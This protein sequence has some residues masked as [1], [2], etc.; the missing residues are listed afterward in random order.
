M[1]NVIAPPANTTNRTSGNQEDKNSYYYTNGQR[2]PLV[3][4]PSV[5]AVRYKVGRDSRDGSLSQEASRLL[6]EV[7]ENIGF[8]PYYAL[9]VYRADHSRLGASLPAY[10][11]GERTLT[12]AVRNLKSESPVEYAAI[13]FRRNK[14]V[15]V[16]NLDDLMFITREFAVQF[17]ENISRRE[18]DEL[19][20]RYRVEIVKELDYAPNGYVLRAPEAEGDNGPVVLANLYY[21]SGMAVFAHPN[22]VQRHHL[23]Q[24]ILEKE[25]SKVKKIVTPLAVRE[26]QPRTEF[27]SQQWHLQTAKVTDA[28]NI[29]K[30][31]NTIKVAILDDGVDTG[32]PEFD[33][34]VVV[35]F[36]FATGDSDGNPNLSSENHGTACAGVA[37]AKGVK[38]SGA[39]PDCS[40]IA[41]HTPDFLGTVEEAEMFQWVADQG[42]DVISCSWGPADGTGAVD[43]LPDNVRAAIHYCVTKG[44][45]GKG[46]PVF[47]AAGNGNESVS[48]DGYAANP[49]VFAVGA[50][51][52]NERRAWYSDFGPEVFI[53]APSSGDRS[54]RRIFTVDRRGN[55]GYNPDP[56]T[57][58]SHPA[59][60]ND[61]TDDFGGTSSAT[62]L[63]A[64]I[65]G[66]ILSVKPELTVQQ[67]RE[68]LRDTT[69]KIDQA[70]GNYDSNGHSNLY[71]YGR[72]NALKAVEK[73][74]GTS[75][76][77]GGGGQPTGQL[78]ITGPSSISRQD[79]APTFQIG[80]GG[81]A[82][83]AVEVATR[84]DLFDFDGHGSER[85][86]GNF[87]ASWQEAMLT[88][89]PFT[90][91]SAAWDQLKQ[92][93]QLFYRL[94]VA[95]DNNWSNHAA[96]VNDSDAS[97]AP[98]MQITGGGGGGGE[99]PNTG[100]LFI[101]GPSSISREDPAPTFQIGMGGRAM[102]A[103]EV[104]IRADLFD[105]DGHGSE[106]NDG[107][108]YA[109]WQDAM[110][111]QTPFTLPSAAWDQLKQANQLFYRLHVADDNN[112]SNHAA[113]VNDSDA[114]SAPS[115]QITDGTRLGRREM[116]TPAPRKEGS[117]TYFNIWSAKKEDEL[118]WR[119]QPLYQ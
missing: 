96:T 118:L 46:I 29:T 93:N 31:S 80:M 77:G 69:D 113:T 105:F 7:S 10:G 101:T 111:T 25:K 91:P 107:N 15:P 18:I 36:D 68:I 71:G 78:F 51:T 27:L 53:C 4:D 114:S 110:L 74:R 109:S 83:Y 94:H 42:A 85:N 119:G 57:G 90:L 26:V 37:V 14:D 32:H 112:W 2:I 12:A 65:T 63:V 1:K 20:S 24:G 66:L 11:N 89:T 40:L 56:D 30:G 61:Y 92:A 99:Q 72:V 73:A 48:N 52:N 98:S 45:G 62:P 22:F 16:R 3:K 70:N 64:G 21:E 106:R 59:G 58:V 84:S 117:L 13:A 81:R 38:A 17:K 108:F 50:S 104:A 41:I 19:N 44:R 9:Q 79:A 6:H 115:M 60:D 95:D 87:Y 103:V 75:G 33:G 49:E 86:D 116:G 100:Q 102:Y 67:V 82:M 28:W 55:N 34:K 54:E 23:R 76:G 97:S 39:A 47:W 35:Q 5:F 88:Q 8:I 43:P